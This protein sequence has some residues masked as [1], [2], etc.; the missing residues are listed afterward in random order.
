MTFL[1]PLFRYRSTQRQHA[2]QHPPIMRVVMLGGEAGHYLASA[3]LAETVSITIPRCVPQPE[4]ALDEVALGYQVPPCGTRQQNGLSFLTSGKPELPD[5][6]G[7]RG[8]VKDRIG[9]QATSSTSRRI[10]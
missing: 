4:K 7:G 3:Q 10:N 2:R 1:A 8:S 5:F 9:H 6:G